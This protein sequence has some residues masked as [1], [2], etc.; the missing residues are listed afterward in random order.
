LKEYLVSTDEKI[1]K[2]LIQTLE[3]GKLGFESAAEKLDAER[4]DVA[5]SFR[6]FSQERA[7]MST[8]L[9]SIA[10]AYGD[11]IEQ[12][13]TVPGALHRGWMAVKDALTSDDAAAVINAAETGE[14]HA[15]EEYQEA[16]ADT[17]VSSEFRVIL[18]RQLASVQA[19]HDYVRGLVAA[20]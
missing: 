8:E 12:R 16:L 14:D 20:T 10:A 17:E 6:K 19:A 11:D 13:S 4:P 2:N 3:N 5:A 1:A 9:A 7:A 18:T 15:V